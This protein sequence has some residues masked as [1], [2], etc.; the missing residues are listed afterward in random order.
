MISSIQVFRAIAAILIV[1][2]HLREIMGKYFQ[3]PLYSEIWSFGKCGVQFFF[4]LSGFILLY[5]HEKEFLQTKKISRYLL[6]R[7]IIIYPIYWIVTLAL[8]PFWLLI[9]SFGEQYHKSISSLFSSLLLIPQ[10]HA[11][12]LGVAWALTHEMFFYL[13]FCLFFITNKFFLA[14]LFYCLIILVNSFYPLADYWQVNFLLSIN[15]LLFCFGLLIAA[16]RLRLR[17]IKG[18][19]LFC[20]GCLGVIAG[21]FMTMKTL[22]SEEAFV[23][24]FGTCSAL[25]IMASAT[26]GIEAWFEN[27]ATLKTI[28]NASY[29]IYLVHYPFL[30]LSSKILTTLDLQNS[31]PNIV[32]WLFLLISSIA[33]GMIFYF[34]IEKP[35]ISFG[36]RY[37]KSIS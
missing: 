27:R 31:F 9:P 30:S 36:S 25:I 22:F 23:L 7:F 2:F 13:I 18:E 19:Y 8:T 3:S 4:V 5:T 17:S 10:E 1:L 6:K 20:M 28:G 32:L 37:I 34:C 15:N 26:Q 33:V 16:Q 35:I 12:H 29:S 14:C 21:S 24:W 11:P